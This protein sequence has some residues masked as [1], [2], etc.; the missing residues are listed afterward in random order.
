ALGSAA[1]PRGSPLGRGLI[2]VYVIGMG[3][4]G[5]HPQL[6]ER[7]YRPP[8]RAGSSPRRITLFLA[9][10]LVP[11]VVWGLE[12]NRRT[13][14]PAQALSFVFPVGTPGVFLWLL[15]TS[16]G[17]T[18]R[19]AQERADELARRSAALAV[20]A[21]QQRD[22]QRQLAHRAMHDPLTGLSNRLVLTER[23]EW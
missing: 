2:G 1:A 13:T 12:L 22:L 15:V 19:V 9:L 7:T 17:R 4:A 18:A 10:A 14:E 5:L 8:D 11:A 6:N 23:M 3:L 20:A 16:L 21:S